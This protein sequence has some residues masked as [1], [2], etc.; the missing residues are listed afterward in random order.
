M[1]VYKS[2]LSVRMNRKYFYRDECIQKFF[3]DLNVFK[4]FSID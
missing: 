4:K 3:I 1:N 2:F